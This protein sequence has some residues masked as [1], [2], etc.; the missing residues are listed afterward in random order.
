MLIGYARTSTMEQNAGLEVQVRDLNAAGCEKLFSE[1]VSSTAHRPKLDRALESLRKGDVLVVT[2]LDRLA[3]SMRNLLELVDTI[4]NAG[5]SLRRSRR[6]C[7]LALNFD[8]A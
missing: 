7:A 2:K 6:A 3:R 1:Q 4:R 5:A 8:V